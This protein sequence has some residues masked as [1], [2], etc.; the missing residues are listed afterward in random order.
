MSG[1]SPIILPDISLSVNYKIQILF[2][3]PEPINGA[4]TVEITK[5]Y[6]IYWDVTRQIPVCGFIRYKTPFCYTVEISKGI[7]TFYE[8]SHDNYLSVDLYNKAFLFLLIPLMGKYSRDYKRY[9]T[10]DIT[11]KQVYML[12]MCLLCLYYVCMSTYIPHFLSAYS[13]F[14]QGISV[15]SVTT[16]MPVMI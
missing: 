2:V 11:F 16:D 5:V 3:S 4:N 12:F 8:V 1:V 6:N 15:V 10:F 7:W 13:Y 9:K 14:P